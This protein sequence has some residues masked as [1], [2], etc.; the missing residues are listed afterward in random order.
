[1]LLP[2]LLCPSTDIMIGV[3]H[4]YPPQQVIHCISV[5]RSSAALAEEG[6]SDLHQLWYPCLDTAARCG[7]IAVRTSQLQLLLLLL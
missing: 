1:M 5:L 2:L 6:M 7:T 4:S 3:S